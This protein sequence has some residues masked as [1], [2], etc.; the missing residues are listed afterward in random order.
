MSDTRQIARSVFV[1]D[2]A[3]FMAFAGDAQGG[4]RP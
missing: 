2:M 3:A 4:G 1:S